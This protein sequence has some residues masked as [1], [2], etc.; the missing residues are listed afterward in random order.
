MWCFAGDFDRGGGGGGFL[1]IF[2]KVIYY[3]LLSKFFA[4]I[5]DTS[6]L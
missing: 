4:F 6:H 1:K 3:S 2:Y 5:F